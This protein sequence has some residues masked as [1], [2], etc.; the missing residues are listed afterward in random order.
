M[1]LAVNKENMSQVIYGCNRQM[2]IEIQYNVI[3]R[4]FDTVW[5]S[6]QTF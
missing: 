4:V 6:K 5:C 3:Q 1:N 2:L